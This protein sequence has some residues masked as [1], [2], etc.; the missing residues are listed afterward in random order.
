[1]LIGG[2][3]VSAQFLD[4]PVNSI[5]PRRDCDDDDDSVV[6]SAIME[7]LDEPLGSLWHF[8][9]ELGEKPGSASSIFFVHDGLKYVTSKN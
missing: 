4:L 5:N 6:I 8:H 9:I 3:Y 1:M 2:H 7:W